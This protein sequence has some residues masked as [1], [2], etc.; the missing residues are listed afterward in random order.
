MQR[1]DQYWKPN[2]STFWVLAT[3]EMYFKKLI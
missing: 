3:F 1:Y 2:R